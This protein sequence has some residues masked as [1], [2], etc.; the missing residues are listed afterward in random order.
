MPKV[1]EWAENNYHHVLIQNQLSDLVK[2]NA[3]WRDYA[4]H[5][6]E[7]GKGPFLS[8]N[9]AVP[10]SNFSEMMLAL[11]VLDLPAK[12][13]EHDTQ[14]QEAALDIVAASPMLIFHKQIQEALVSDDKTPVLVGQNF[15]RHGDR[16]LT[17][18]GE[19][20][21]KYVTDE[22]LQ[23]VVYG[24]QVVVTNPTSATNRGCIAAKP[25]NTSRVSV[26]PFARADKI[27][28]S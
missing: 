19:K 21:D 9:V 3:F 5:L 14:R 15:F 23:G 1:K 28:A 11:S 16:F 6:A 27:G 13:G 26:E 8:K 18:D 20:R 2:I 4:A 22:F 7:G 24:C 10:T 25:I 17:V 12:S